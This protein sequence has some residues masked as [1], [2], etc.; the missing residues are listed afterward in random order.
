MLVQHM[1][2][3]Q[4]PELAGEDCGERL[5]IL[6][7]EAHKDV[8]L[9]GQFQYALG[10]SRTSLVLVPTVEVGEQIELVMELVLVAK[11][12]LEKKSKKGTDVRWKYEMRYSTTGCSTWPTCWH[13]PS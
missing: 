8:K 7:Q 3:I 6:Y 13:L 12:Q 1:K 2:C 11:S 10:G 9:R 5:R 4:Q